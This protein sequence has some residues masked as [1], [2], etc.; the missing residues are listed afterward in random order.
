MNSPNAT[1]L[2]GKKKGENM[3]MA[4]RSTVENIYISFGK[5]RDIDMY[6]MLHMSGTPYLFITLTL[7]KKKMEYENGHIYIYVCMSES[8]GGHGA[9]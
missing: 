7:Y 8:F 2:Q 1:F 3:K 9:L 5:L 4:K 6:P